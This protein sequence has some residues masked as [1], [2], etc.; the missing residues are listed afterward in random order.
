MTRQKLT[1]SKVKA[2]K[3]KA[4]E[5][6]L[7][8][9]GGMYLFVT[10]TGT[11]SWRLDYTFNEKRKT[12][13]IGKY[14]AISLEKARHATREAKNQ[15]ISGIDPGKTKSALKA[16]DSDNALIFSNFAR[17]WWLHNK[18]LWSP[19]HAERVWRKL[20]LNVLPALGGTHIKN[21]TSQQVLTTVQNIER[22]GV[23]DIP[24]RV[25][26]IIKNIFTHAVA[27]GH[28]PTNPASDLNPL[29]KKSKPAHRASMPINEIGCFL[30]RLDTYEGN[31]VTALALKL[32][33]L[34]MF[35][36]GE[37]RG[38]RWAEIDYSNK[39]WRIPGVRKHDNGTTY[40]GMKMKTEHIVPLSTQAITTLQELN[41]ITGQ[42]S[43]MFPSQ[44]DPSSKTISENTLNKALAKL[45]Y[46]GTVA[47]KSKATAHGFRS[48]AASKLNESGFNSDA[49]ELQLS[50]IERN[51]VK[52]AYTYHATHM[53]ERVKMMQ[54]WGDHLDELKN[55]SPNVS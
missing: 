9:G 50:H 2:A 6:K 42:Y 20:E 10:R 22:R 28:I 40:L 53:D 12:L 38:G 46:D 54:W 29:L 39:Q 16:S 55:S 44:R 45:G 27:S 49:I 33:L 21:I 11:K 8:D 7:T 35:R 47:G 14:P 4:S 25:L 36:P 30:T 34:T 26:G 43:L 37:I 1:D 24:K 32:T 48:T 52:A 3:P 23:S 19:N 31:R 41:K 13:T 5:Y 18:G 15:I 17:E 51:S